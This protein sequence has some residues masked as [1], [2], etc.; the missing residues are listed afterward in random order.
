MSMSMSRSMSI[1]P[2]RLVVGI[3]VAGLALASPAMA[4][5]APGDEYPPPPSKALLQQTTNAMLQPSDVPA[6][7]GGGDGLDIGYRIPPGGQDPF[8]LCFNPEEGGILPQADGAIGY[9]STSGQVTQEIYAYASAADAQSAWSQLNK[10]VSVGCT[11]VEEDEGERITARTGT[12]DSGQQVGRWVRTD[13]NRDSL[14]AFF[15]VVGPVDDALVITR[16]QG[17]TGLESTTARQREAT[18]ELFDE[19]VQRY[20]D[21]ASLGPLQPAALTAAEQRMIVPADL[22]EALTTKTAIDGGWADFR[23]QIPAEQPFNS[24]DPSVD[25]M[26]VGTGLFEGNFGASGDVVIDEGN[27]G[28]Q[29]FTYESPAAAQSAWSELGRNLQACERSQGT[30]FKRNGG[31][32]GEVG[33]VDIG[34]RTGLWTR[35]I[36]SQ[37]A[38]RDFTLTTKA[39]SVYLMDATTIVSVSYAKS[40]QRAAQFPLDQ[41]AVN[42][43]ATTL[44]ERWS[45]P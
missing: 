31:F 18:H 9:F 16:F 22:P 1:V 33:Q 24:C 8:P 41:E 21:R 19:L 12:L 43:V 32:R 7:L 2:P 23:A 40:I 4:H 26:P 27:L 25:L 44:L 38:G 34:G 30:L 28:Q 29:V 14:P 5:A 45:T 13:S 6:A 37:I 20:A 39:Y 17:K 10:A 36:D 42:A 11:F 35:A 3:A 15:S